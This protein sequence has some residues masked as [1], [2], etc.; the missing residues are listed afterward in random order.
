MLRVIGFSYSLPATT[1]A[2]CFEGCGVWEAH[3]RHREVC[4][5][6]SP[7]VGS[8]GGLFS[9]SHPR[10]WLKPQ[11]HHHVPKVDSFDL[12]FS[13]LTPLPGSQ[14]GAISQQVSVS[15]M[16]SGTELK[17]YGLAIGHSIIAAGW[18]K[19][20]TFRRG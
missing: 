10:G 13:N 8:L 3:P 9:K 16:A 18:L 11:V 14:R 4:A 15:T 6:P 20:D 2:F 5:R 1:M 12:R 19:R 7:D 17:V